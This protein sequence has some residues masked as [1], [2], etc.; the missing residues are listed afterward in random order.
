LKTLDSNRWQALW[1]QLGALPPI[2]SFEQLVAAYSEAQRHYHGATHIFACLEHLDRYQ[3]LCAQPALAELALWTHDLIYDTRRQDN[4]AASA[5]LTAD[6]LR[7]A[8]IAQH[9]PAVSEMIL[10]TTH[11][12]PAT[13]DAALV[14]DIDLSILAT[15]PELYDAYCAAVRKEFAWVPEPL[16]L[17]GR[18]RLLRSLLEMPR[19]YQC[20]ALGADWEVP[21]RA[22]LARELARLG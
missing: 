15:P 13:G 6:W 3:A 12:A 18:A 20:A 17:Q 16:F 8:G 22:N 11:L 19:L 5:A 9:I 2:G 14:V 10:A 7:K 4:E 21:A 1:E